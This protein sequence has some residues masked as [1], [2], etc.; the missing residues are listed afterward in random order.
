MRNYQ[1]CEVASGR[2]TRFTVENQQKAQFADVWNI[3]GR[4]SV[5]SSIVSYTYMYNF[6]DVWDIKNM[7]FLAH[8]GRKAPVLINFCHVRSKLHV[9]RRKLGVGSSKLQISQIQFTIWVALSHIASRELEIGSSKLQFSQLSIY[10]L[11]WLNEQKT[12][13]NVFD[14]ID[15]L[16]SISALIAETAFAGILD[17]RKG[18]SKKFTIFSEQHDQRVN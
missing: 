11:W 14:K 12:F 16:V 13:G 2:Y 15:D 18:A 3:R 8:F 7:A 9:A 17:F 10:A 1:E 4:G 6:T 5:K